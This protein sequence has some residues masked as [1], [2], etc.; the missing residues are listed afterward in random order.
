[1]RVSERA[2]GSH[3]LRVVVQKMLEYQEKHAHCYGCDQVVAVQGVNESIGKVCR[4]V[5][6]VISKE[7]NMR[8]TQTFFICCTFILAVFLFVSC[9]QG[10]GNGAPAKPAAQQPVASVSA[11]T[12]AVTYQQIPTS[13]DL[14]VTD[15]M[16]QNASND[17]HNWLTYGHDYTS[18]R[19]VNLN[20]VNTSNVASLRPVY[21]VQT[22]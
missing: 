22:G 20:Q 15:S 11:P 14:N 1:M 17:T 12:Q 9:Q 3:A 5:R 21:A 13:I 2:G 7:K 16:L 18:D 19:Y 6:Q 8:R 4:Y 10:G